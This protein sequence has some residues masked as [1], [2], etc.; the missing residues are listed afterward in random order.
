MMRI[1]Q[2]KRRRDYKNEYSTDINKKQDLLRS[3]QTI[4]S[5][6]IITLEKSENIEYRT[7]L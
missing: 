2:T 7:S 1:D 6:L 5:N 3:F 4:A